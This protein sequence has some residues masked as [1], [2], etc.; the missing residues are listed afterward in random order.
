MAAADRHPTVS[1]ESTPHLLA[2]VVSDAGALAAGHLGRMQREIGDEFQNLKL[3]MAKVAIAIGI[4]VVGALLIGE[5]LAALLIAL[6]VAPWASFGIIAVVAIAG[7]L[8]VLRR[9]PKDKTDMDLVPEEAI[10]SF[11]RDVERVRTAMQA[12]D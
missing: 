9:M 11:R 3:A 4:V 7:G 8:L 12:R 2:A 1:S 5:S 6:G 10:A